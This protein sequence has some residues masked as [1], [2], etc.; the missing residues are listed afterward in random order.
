MLDEMPVQRITIVIV[1]LSVKY[2]MVPNLVN[3]F[4]RNEFFIRKRKT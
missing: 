2:V 4:G 1:F 3:V